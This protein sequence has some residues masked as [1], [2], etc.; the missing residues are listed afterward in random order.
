MQWL[1]LSLA[2][3]C[4]Y[5]PHECDHAV[6]YKTGEQSRG[7]EGNETELYLSFTNQWKIF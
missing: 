4:G 2:L 3:S 1:L 7:F 5:M 6:L